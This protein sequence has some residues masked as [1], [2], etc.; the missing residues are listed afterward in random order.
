MPLQSEFRCYTDLLK[1]WRDSASHGRAVHMT[2]AEAF[3]ALI[4]LLRFTIF[5]AEYRAEI[6]G[7]S[8]AS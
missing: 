1:H 5:A 3:G 6:V 4:L 2:E 7:S 8:S